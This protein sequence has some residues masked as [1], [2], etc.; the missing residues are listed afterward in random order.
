MYKHYI[1]LDNTDR[2]IK[3]FS[4]VFE[5]PL[6]GDICINVDGGYQFRLEPD[7]E[8]NPMLT[9]YDGIPLYK[10]DGTAVVTRSTDEVE[11]DRAALPAPIVTIPIDQQ[12]ATMA[13]TQ[14]QQAMVITDLQQTN[15][16]L[17]LQLA[18]K[19]GKA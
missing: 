4:D 19:G 12:L 7:G 6:G 1:R 9:D 2:I 13:L 11:A 17:M 14:A 16:A 5:P 10:H 3:G 8:E 15:A 18:E